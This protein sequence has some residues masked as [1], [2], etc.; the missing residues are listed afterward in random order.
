[1]WRL[2]QRVG[3]EV[4]QCT[5]EPLMPRQGLRGVRCDKQFTAVR[6]D[7]P[8]LRPSDRM[9]RDYTAQRP[10]QLWVLGF[11]YVPTWSGMGFP[12]FVTDV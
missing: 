9:Q 10:N 8:A 2:L 12:A 4:H 6:A 3:V 7:S 1:M 11:T 5:G